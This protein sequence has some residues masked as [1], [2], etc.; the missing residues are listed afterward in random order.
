MKKASK[1]AVEGDD[2]KRTRK[3][4]KRDCQPAIKPCRDILQHYAMIFLAQF[5]SQVKGPHGLLR[6]R[7]DLF[8]A[9][10]DA[11]VLPIHDIELTLNFVSTLYEMT[12]SLNT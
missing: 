12:D 4:A 2:T 3:N 1:L 11:V 8:A 6:L 7:T 9:D 10:W 5:L